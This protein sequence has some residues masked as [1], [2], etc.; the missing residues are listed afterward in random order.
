MIAAVEAHLWHWTG[1]HVGARVQLADLLE[2]NDLGPEPMGFL[3]IADVQNNMI[4]SDWRSAI[5]G[6]VCVIV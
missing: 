6:L 2:A 4:H 5:V 1:T 3:D